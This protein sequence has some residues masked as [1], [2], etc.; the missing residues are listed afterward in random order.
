MN[1]N[2]KTKNKTMQYMGNTFI[3]K[4]TTKK[5]REWSLYSVHLLKEGNQE[6]NK[7]SCFEQLGGKSLH[8]ADLQ[9]GQKYHFAYNEE[10]QTNPEGKEYISKTIFSIK[11]ATTQGQ[12]IPEQKSSLII[13]GV[14]DFVQS[15]GQMVKPELWNLDHMLTVWFKTMNKEYVENLTVSFNAW[16]E[17]NKK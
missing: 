13:D 8:L 1:E 11:E 16:L 10:P 15:Y 4:G 9:Q 2:Q 17:E 6:P 7:F 14:N 5:G 3:K 12:T